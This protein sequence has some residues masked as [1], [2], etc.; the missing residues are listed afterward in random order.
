MGGRL[1]Y[2]VWVDG[3]TLGAVV[4]LI[5]TNKTVSQLEHVGSQGDDDE[6]SI[7]GPFLDVVG[8][9]G[10]VLEIQSSID[11]VHHIERCWLI[12]KISKY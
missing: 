5:D 3:H 12:S 1:F 11:L 6:L 4:C 9:N 2:Q 8:H 10:D 7:S